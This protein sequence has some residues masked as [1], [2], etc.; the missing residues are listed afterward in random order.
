M[1]ASK[2]ESDVASSEADARQSG[3]RVPE[4]A[5]VPPALSSSSALGKPRTS[6]KKGRGAGLRR[7]LVV[8]VALP[9]LAAIAYA[10]VPAPVK[11]DLGVVHRSKLSIYVSEDGRSRVRERYIVSAPLTG[12]LTR[13]GLEP[14]DDVHEGDV[15]FRLVP[16]APAL[17]DMRSRAEAESRLLAAEARKGQAKSG[18]ALVQTQHEST[19]REEQRARQLASQGLLS[20]EQLERAELAV[21]LARENLSA[22]ELS[23]RAAEAD[24]R[25]ARAVLGQ[26]RR[27][28][29]EEIP[30]PA[31]ASGRVLRVERESGGPVA[32]GSPVL[33]IGDVSQMEVV[34]D[35]LSSDALQIEPGS[36]VLLEHF[37]EAKEFTGHV[38]RVEPA[39]FTHLSALGVEEQRVNVIVT[40]GEVPPRLGDGYRVEARILI[41]EADQALTVPASATF[42]NGEQW[43]VYAVR[44]GRAVLQ[45]VELGRHGRLE[46]EVKAGL[47]EGMRVVLYPGDRIRAGARIE[48]R[49]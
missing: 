9:G 4:P 40:L 31:P 34:V 49:E 11:V 8:L 33:E 48:A 13:L 22:A 2:T 27:G 36:R 42:R 30:M 14:G 43:A 17:L 45:P 47:S 25:T 23:V 19:L 18:V 16:P 6:K 24:V 12:E 35:V 32:V 15:V 21:R 39:A 5:A 28:T 44:D 1:T 46:A 26:V 20:D 3:I 41:W 29:Q 7:W 10:F 37:G 38:R